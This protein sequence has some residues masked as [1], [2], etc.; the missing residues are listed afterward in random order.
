VIDILKN[1]NLNQ[2]EHEIIKNV[3]GFRYPLKM[4]ISV[5]E[6]SITVITTYPLKK[7]RKR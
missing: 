7:G 6:D 4:V 5:G 3:P 1:M 2:D